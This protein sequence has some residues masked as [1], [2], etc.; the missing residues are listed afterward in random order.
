MFFL[1]RIICDTSYHNVLLLELVTPLVDFCDE[2]A[3]VRLDF[4]ENLHSIST[5]CELSS[6]IYLAI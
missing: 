3:F 6:Q 2:D 5:I 4:A 1:Y